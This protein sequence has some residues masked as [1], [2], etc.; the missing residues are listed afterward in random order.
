MTDYRVVDGIAS[1]PKGQQL[2][3][4]GMAEQNARRLANEEHVT[5]SIRIAGVSNRPTT[6][7]RAQQWWATRQDLIDNGFPTI[8]GMPTP[9]TKAQS[10]AQGYA[11]HGDYRAYKTGDPRKGNYHSFFHATSGGVVNAKQTTDEV[12]ERQKIYRQITGKPTFAYHGCIGNK[13]CPQWNPNTGKLSSLVKIYTT[14]RLNNQAV[15]TSDTMFE[16]MPIGS[17]QGCIGDCRPSWN[18]ASLVA[19]DP[20]HYRYDKW[21]LAELIPEPEPEPEPKIIIEPKTISYSLP[22]IAGVVIVI[23]LLLRRKNA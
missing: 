16:G 19:T 5:G 17:E 23:L 12:L 14:R 2:Y 1:T 10:G 7:P 8:D 22:L 4:L 9:V 6:A 21:G 13:R 15:E 20:E 18:K 3:D 11:D